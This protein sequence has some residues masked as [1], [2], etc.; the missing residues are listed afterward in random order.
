MRII[1]IFNNNIVATR[2]ENG[3]EMILTGAGIGFQKKLGDL[4]SK[5]RIEKVYEVREDGKDRLYRLFGDTPMELIDAAQKI[6]DRAKD[7]LGIQMTMQALV[8]MIDHITYAVERKKSGL[9]IP[10]LMLH[11]IKSLYPEE[12]QVGLLGLQFIQDATGVLL[13]EHEAG[14]VTMHMVNASLGENKES[15]SKIFLFTSGIVD[16]IED[17][18]D[19]DFDEDE[20]S[21]ARLNSH[22]KFLAKRILLKQPSTEDQ[23][24]D[25]YEM[26][27][28]KDKRYKSVEKKIK[29]FVYKNFHHEVTLQEMVY[30]MVHINKAISSR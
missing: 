11:E 3:E 13:S 23:V 7:E 25:F 16:I 30:L 12:F 26:F 14:Y 2:S 9:E 22:L 20:I 1:K 28:K 15:I 19:I 29:T 4:V 10:N 24:E 17:V 8:G 18:F 5:D 27:M 21:L 6:R